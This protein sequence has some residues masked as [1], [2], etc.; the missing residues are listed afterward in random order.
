LFSCLFKVVGLYKPQFPSPDIYKLPDEKSMLRNKAVNNMTPFLTG[1]LNEVL[2]ILAALPRKLVRH[3]VVL[4]YSSIN[5]KTRFR[6]NIIL[7]SK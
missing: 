5:M 1:S 7:I 3:D 4:V 6:N 2:K